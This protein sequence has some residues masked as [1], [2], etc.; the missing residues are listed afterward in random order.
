MKRAG[1][2][3]STMLLFS[4]SLTGCIEEK[5]DYW[6]DPE[7]WGC[8]INAEY[9]LECTEYISALDSPIHSVTHPNDSEIWFVEQSG[10]IRSW[11]GEAL[12][13]IADISSLVNRCHTE[14]GLL[15]LAFTSE[16]G[17]LI[18]YVEKGTCDGPNDAGL[19]LAHAS[20][21]GD[22]RLD[23]TSIKSLMEIEQPKRNHNGGHVL[24][25]ENGNYL[26]GLGDGGGRFDPDGN[27]QNNSN[28]LGSILL[29]SYNNETITPVLENNGSNPFILHHGLRNPWRFDVDPEDRLWI[30]D[31]GQNC[32]EEV[33]L[34][35]MTE[36]KNMGWAIM[37]GF[38][39]IS[40]NCDNSE[41]FSSD[42]DEFTEPVFTYSHEGGNCS[43]TG[44]FWMNWGPEIL[45]DGYL[46][47]DFCTGNIWL[48]KQEN[49]AWVDRH[50]G[51]SGVMIVGFGRGLNDDLLVFHWTGEVIQIL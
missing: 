29:F 22:G 26:W 10:L 17:V 28:L 40:E 1:F 5:S 19:I 46:F 13:E 4:S 18:S 47:G 45:R 37:E 48:L 21:G 24:S 38:F 16:K 23:L 51:T 31:V 41:N 15:G 12:S 32:W 34:V 33:N 50:I 6:P 8:Q 25:L 49:G 9:D 36:Q 14:Q 7:S 42:V 35:S 44:G 3:L 2:L 43:I 39:P 11:D 30:A 20:I 27:G